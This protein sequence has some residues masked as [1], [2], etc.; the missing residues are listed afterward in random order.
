M[1]TACYQHNS[2]TF[3]NMALSKSNRIVLLLVVDVAFFLV[4]LIV[5]MLPP[6]IQSCGCLT[7]RQDMPFIL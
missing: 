5:G 2:F 6:Q 7:P 1:Q 4:E 3:R